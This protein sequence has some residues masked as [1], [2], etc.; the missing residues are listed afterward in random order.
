[1]A[2]RQDFLNKQQ[3]FNNMWGLNIS[4]DAI[5]V[6][7]KQEAFLNKSKIEISESP[8][9]HYLGVLESVLSTYL[10]HHSAINEETFYDKMR[11]FSLTVFLEDFEDL[12][13]VKYA[14]EN[15]NASTR[16]A[17]EGIDYDKLLGALSDMV[18]VYNKSLSDVWAKNVIDGM[19]TVEE[20]RAITDRGQVR[21]MS[22]GVDPTYLSD[23]EQRALKNI[24]AAHEAITKVREQ[25]SAGWHWVPWHWPQAIREVL[26]LS[27]LTK[28][29]EELAARNYSFDATL[30]SVNEKLL[31]GLAKDNVQSEDQNLN[32]LLEN[33]PEN[34]L[35]NNIENNIEKN[36]ENNIENDVK[37][38]NV[39]KN[40]SYRLDVNLR[41]TDFV[42]NLVESLPAKANGEPVGNNAKDAVVQ[43][44]SLAKVFLKNYNSKYDEAQAKGESGDAE[45]KEEVGIIFYQAKILS[46]TLGYESEKEQYAVAQLITDK[47]MKEYSAAH[48]NK[49]ME[50]YANGYVLSGEN[51]MPGVLGY[52]SREEA[53]EALKVY[54][55]YLPKVEDDKKDNAIQNE[56]NVK[57]D[58]VARQ[59]FIGELKSD[60]DVNIISNGEKSDFVNVKE[61]KEQI[62][63]KN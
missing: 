56:E 61:Q 43:F 42:N 12:M 19:M 2:T 39:V 29:K 48:C 23:P 60:V 18:E 45:M 14:A 36:I 27:K 40:V 57:E 50:K 58:N 17:Y 33:N 37:L 22:D 5:E 28:Q 44:M 25:R 32:D 16:T 9:K 3:N 30:A 54:K 31:G 20:M 10:H 6:G 46:E 63:E 24:V 49:E 13:D 55:N 41:T 47:V 62:I 38:D 21:L 59:E 15:P 4:I 7:K 8:K 53:Q 51:E 35:Q 52:V 34:D 1:M 26:Y 11:S